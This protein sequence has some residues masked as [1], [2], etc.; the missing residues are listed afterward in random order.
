M[1][2]TWWQRFWRWLVAIE[3]IVYVVSAYEF[4]VAYRAIMPLHTIDF[5]TVP[6]AIGTALGGAMWAVAALAS[7]AAL[8]VSV[9]ILALVELVAWVKRAPRRKGGR[10]VIG[11]SVEV[12][13]WRPYRDRRN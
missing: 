6:G 11:S 7:H 3:A 8:A 9:P 4:D 13:R 10:Q 1:R 5:T 12:E 2:T